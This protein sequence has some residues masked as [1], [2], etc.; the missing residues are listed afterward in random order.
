MSAEERAYVARE[1]ILGRA[2][3]IAVI[4]RSIEEVSQA[5]DSAL[6]RTSLTVSADGGSNLSSVGA[7]YD[8]KLEDDERHGDAVVGIARI[9]EL[10]ASRDGSPA[11][12]HKRDKSVVVSAS[13][14]LRLSISSLTPSL[15]LPLPSIACCT[16]FYLAG[17]HGEVGHGREHAYVDGR[18]VVPA[19]APVKSEPVCAP[20]RKESL[21]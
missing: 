14:S 18:I 17:E 1:P 8:A 10:P 3:I 5:F 7:G 12:F 4:V 19:N 9:E 20:T 6:A 16:A 2:R 15:P 13:G 21:I 11:L